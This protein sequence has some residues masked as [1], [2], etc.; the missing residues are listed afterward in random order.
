MRAVV[1]WSGGMS[2]FLA[3]GRALADPDL[4]VVGLVSCLDVPETAPEPAAPAAAA[5]LRGTIAEDLLRTQARLLGLPWR[6]THAGYDGQELSRAATAW[7]AQAIVFGG[8]PGPQVPSA[9]SIHPVAE[10]RAAATATFAS[11]GHQAVITAI[12]EPHV[13]WLGRPIDAGFAHY[14]ATAGPLRF[15]SFVHASPARRSGVPWRAMQAAPADGLA[16]LRLLPGDPSSAPSRNP[17]LSGVPLF[18]PP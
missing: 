13:A 8:A 15:Q 2:S 3:L 11:R 12:E 10:A 14:L 16:R 9:R 1:A 7:D 6:A 18:G 4:E 17:D 5:T